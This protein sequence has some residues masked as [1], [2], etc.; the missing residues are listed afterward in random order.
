[1]SSLAPGDL[2]RRLGLGRIH[3]AP[4]A[5]GSGIMLRGR[6][7]YILPTRYG[8]MFGVLLLIMLV[9][10]INYGNNMGFLLTFILTSASISS[11]FHT[12]RNLHGIYVA[13]GRCGEF[14][15][16]EPMV[17]PLLLQVENQRPRPGIEVIGP[18]GEPQQVNVPASGLAETGVLFT[19]VRR[20]W[21]KPGVVRLETR[22]PFGLFRAWA[23]VELQRPCLVYP[24]VGPSGRTI[25]PAA[26]GPLTMEGSKNS[27]S[28]DYRGLR[29]WQPGDS[30][31]MIHW[32]AAA[33]ET[34]ELMS[35]VF[36]SQAAGDM[37]L[38]WDSLPEL[39]R[40]QRLSQLCRWVL[41]LTAQGIGFGLR[42]PG[43]EIDPGTGNEQKRRC[44]EA[45]AKFPS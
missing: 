18:V 19:G 7:I 3:R 27:G 35:K 26:I 15:A 31:R 17:Y 43:T 6:S 16:G 32:K 23:Y 10:S 24:M 4:A 44:L 40:E 39:G 20:G 34:K 22:Y 2:V 9:G 12:F 42:I 28:D 38:D 25:P 33:C 21:F 29:S 5:G 1:M 36:G 8:M 30:P 11:L 41:D 13:S 37:W 45:L 14:Y